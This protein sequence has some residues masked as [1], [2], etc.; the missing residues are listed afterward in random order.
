M[1]ELQTIGNKDCALSLLHGTIY[2]LKN[3]QPVKFEVSAILTRLETECGARP[4]RKGLWLGLE[5]AGG[6]GGGGWEEGQL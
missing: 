1:K 2:V 5:G 4:K 3:A 6:C